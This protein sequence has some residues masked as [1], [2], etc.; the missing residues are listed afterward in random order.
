MDAYQPGTNPEHLTVAVAGM[1]E[2]LVFPDNEAEDYRRA[3]S[4]VTDLVSDLGWN[5]DPDSPGHNDAV[6][7]LVAIHR[8]LPGLISDPG[9]LR[10]YGIALRKLADTEIPD[11]FDPATD[12]AAALRFGVLGTALF[13]PLILALRKLA[14]VDRIRSTPAATWTTPS[15]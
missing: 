9:Q 7:A 8:Y 3:E 13:E 5:V 2:P 1:S 15:D 14:H 12:P 6:R 10:P 11:S 4:E